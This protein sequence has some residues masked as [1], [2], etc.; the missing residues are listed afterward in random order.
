MAELGFVCDG[1]NSYQIWLGACPNQTRMSE[2][3][4][5]KMKLNKL[6]EVMFYP[7]KESYIP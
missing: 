5:D 1:P 6:E 2:A 3:Y 7:S 4:M